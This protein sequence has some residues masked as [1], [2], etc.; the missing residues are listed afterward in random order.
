MFIFYLHQDLDL[1][2]FQIVD[3]PEN[4]TSHLRLCA[5][6]MHQTRQETGGWCLYWFVEESRHILLPEPLCRGENQEIISYGLKYCHQESSTFY[7]FP[8]KI[9]LT[10]PSVP[11]WAYRWFTITWE[12]SSSR[13]GSGWQ[14]TSLLSMT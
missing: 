6:E 2:V 4:K 7:I 9:I 8:L 10:L 3:Y 12:G 1:S 11:T 13:I 14:L 5:R